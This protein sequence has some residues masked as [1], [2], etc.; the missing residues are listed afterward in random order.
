MLAPGIRTAAAE[1]QHLRD[2][3]CSV[4]VALRPAERRETA[5]LAGTEGKR[6]VEKHLTFKDPVETLQELL[7]PGVEGLCE[8]TDVLH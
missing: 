8:D 1:Q 7:S 5:R 4:P 6:G 2:P 3:S